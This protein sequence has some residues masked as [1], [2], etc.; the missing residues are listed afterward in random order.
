MLLENFIIIATWGW[1]LAW[2]GMANNV[3]VIPS[4]LILLVLFAGALIL[5][6]V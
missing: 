4:I 6:L 2:L 3:I 1:K 5:D